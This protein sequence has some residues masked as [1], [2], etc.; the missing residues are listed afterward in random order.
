MLSICIPIYRYSVRPLIQALQKEITGFRLPCQLVCADDGS[1][2]DT[3]SRNAFLEE[4]PTIHYDLLPANIGRAAIR[5]HLARQ[6][7]YP[8]LL[9]MDADVM[10]VHPDFI[11]KY[12]SS[13]DPG[14]LLYGGTTYFSQPPS[15]PAKR[16]HWRYGKAKEEVPVS[17]RNQQEYRT[18]KTN[19]F[20]IPKAIVE[21]HPLDE[22][23]QGY[24]HEDSLLARECALSGIPIRHLD[25]PVLHLGLED[26][27]VLLAKLE[28]S[29]D[30]LYELYLRNE[31]PDTPL[32]VVFRPGPVRWLSG[33]LRALLP[34]LHR[35]LAA[36]PDINLALLDLYKLLYLNRLQ[37]KDAP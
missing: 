4:D 36:E 6:S 35:K 25:N 26:Q 24:G 9:F 17:R 27:P 29:L 10:P 3:L 7:K 33:Q 15:D 19:N 12:L 34:T 1:D 31:L 2:D 22:Q 32:Q 37:E 21:K 5:N 16:F 28:N 8:F 23:L 11:R 30:N 14:A 13:L 18:F 20:V